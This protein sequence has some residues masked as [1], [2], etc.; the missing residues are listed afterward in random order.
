MSHKPRR[1]RLNVV[2]KTEDL[3][4]QLHAWGKLPGG[5]EVALVLR[6]PEGRGLLVLHRG[7][8]LRI[9][10]AGSGADNPGVPVEPIS[11][12]DAM[13]ALK[14][15]QKNPGEPGPITLRGQWVGVLVWEDDQPHVELHRKLSTY[16]TL[17][18][19][20]NP[21]EDGWL[22]TVERQPTKASAW[23]ADPKASPVYGYDTLQKAIERGVV[24]MMELVQESCAK[25]DTH[26]RAA[27]DPGY[28]ER[29]P[30]RRRA[31]KPSPVQKF[32][33]RID[34]KPV[35]DGEPLPPSPDNVVR[36][37]E[38]T[39][40]LTGEAE[41]IRQEVALDVPAAPAHDPREL[42]DWFIEQDEPVLERVGKQLDAYLHG[43]LPPQDATVPL[44][45][46]H[47]GLRAE[48]ARDTGLEPEVRKQALTQL[49]AYAQAMQAAPYVLERA[50]RLIHYAVAAANSPKCQGKDR[51]EA[52]GLI[53]QAITEYEAARTQVLAGETQ[54][55][56][57]RLRV[58]SA[59]VALSAAKSGRSCGRGQ[60]SLTA[61]LE[62]VPPL[63]ATEPKTPPRV[64]AS[65]SS[66]LGQALTQATAHFKARRTQA[67]AKAWAQK[68]LDE[69]GIAPKKLVG[70]KVGA[71]VEVQVTLPA[72]ELSASVKKQLMLLADLA[73]ERLSLT[74]TEAAPRKTASRRTKG[75][76]SKE[77]TGSSKGSAAKSSKTTGSRKRAPK[78]D[79]KKDALL[80]AAFTEAIAE[81]LKE[82]A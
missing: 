57:K 51:T 43:R 45:R 37:R 81:A 71:G 15:A 26:R 23:Y 80:M 50:R 6:V 4:R 20:S 48:V 72:G 22:M 66:K 24:G 64:A 28:A 60:T 35:D 47:A 19:R 11:A 77:S 3:P 10:R 79:E 42:A 53:K 67:R 70:K 46:L 34:C 61:M 14:E 63:V 29:H 32:G 1:I 62:P 16:G 65:A 74:W 54:A 17:R 9:W 69:L 76:T 21:G 18:L 44:A 49:D 56:L 38:A 13:K 31:P 12:C 58:V 59:Q 27:F 5:G 7:E 36:L 8:D 41:A 55:G 78:V 2:G 68:G 39:R 75:T 40:A 73:P 33:R 82:A 52:L 25:R 30:I